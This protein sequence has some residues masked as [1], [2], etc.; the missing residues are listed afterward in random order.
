[1]TKYHIIVALDPYVKLWVGQVF[2]SVGCAYRTPWCD[3]QQQARDFAER[4]LNE[5]LANEPEV[6]Q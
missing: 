2:T 6:P 5:R 1:M 3:D 4:W